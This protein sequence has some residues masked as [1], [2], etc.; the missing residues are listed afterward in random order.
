MQKREAA[1]DVSGYDRL[2]ISRERVAMLSRQRRSTAQHEADWQR[3]LGI[4]GLTDSREFDA[5]EG[6]L[7]PPELQP[8]PAVESFAQSAALLQQQRQ[9]EVSRL[10]ARAVARSRI[11]EITLGLGVKSIDTP[12]GSDSG[13][14]LSASIPLPLF[15]RKQGGRQQATAEAIRAESEY[16]LA[17]RQVQARVRAL[18]HKASLLRANARLFSE[19][20]MAASYELVALAETSYHANEIGVLELIDAYRSA[21]EAEITAL[22]LALESRL[23]SIELDEMTAGVYP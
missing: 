8:F 12:Q 13:L 4:I 9:A 15:D 23:I 10:T 14:M 22:E 19:Q 1:G 20:S 11:P 7:I 17:L 6:Q 18:W 2:R 21:L 3:L 5:V 16:Q